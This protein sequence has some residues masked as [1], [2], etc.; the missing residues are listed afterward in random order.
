MTIC[1]TYVTLLYSPKVYNNNHLSSSSSR[2]NFVNRWIWGG[3]DRGY[4][5]NVD[6]NWGDILQI[7]AKLTGKKEF[8][9]VGLLN[10]NNNELDHWEQLI[11]NVTHVVLELEYAAKNVTWESLY[12][13]WIDEEEETEVLVCP[14]LPSL[15]SPGIRLNLIAVKLPHA[16]GGNWSRDVARLH[17][18]LAVARLTTSFKGNYPLYVPFVTN[19]FPIPNLFTCRELVGHEGNV[20]GRKTPP[21]TRIL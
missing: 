16:N 14:S 20:F 9:E 5:S 13:E 3:L 1:D 4:I 8:Q 18:Q 19:F 10:F 17:L 15:R 21:S 12:P 7:T 2:P 6:I 11:P